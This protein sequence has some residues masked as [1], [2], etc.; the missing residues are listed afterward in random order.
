MI[1]VAVLGIGGRMGSRIAAAVRAEPDLKIAAA[2]ERP[3]SPLIGRDAGVVAG[4]G[5]TGTWYG[6]RQEPYRSQLGLS[7]GYATAAQRFRAAVTS[8]F[9]DVVWGLD[10]DLELR[11]SGIEVVR[12][13]GFAPASA[14]TRY[15]DV[16]A[17]LDRE[18]AEEGRAR[19]AADASDDDVERLAAGAERVL[20]ANWTLLDGVQRS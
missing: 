17:T 6:F 2:T 18:H 20:R 16:H 1:R 5:E 12:F 10:A 15:F 11:A 14:A 9:R 4:I 8:D 7:V 13:Y 3:D 19:L